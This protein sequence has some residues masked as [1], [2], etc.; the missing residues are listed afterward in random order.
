LD[1]KTLEFLKE[2]IIDLFKTYEEPEID[3][4]GKIINKKLNKQLK[5]NE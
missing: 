3:K 1:L 4:D 2:R 5:L